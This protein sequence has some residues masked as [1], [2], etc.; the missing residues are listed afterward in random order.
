MS[1]FLAAIQFDQHQL[2]KMPSFPLVYLQTL[3]QKSVVDGLISRS[4]SIYQSICLFLRYDYWNDKL[5]YAFNTKGINSWVQIFN[6][7]LVPASA[8]AEVCRNAWWY[9]SSST[10]TIEHPSNSSKFQQ[11]SWFLLSLFLK[12]FFIFRYFENCL[13][14]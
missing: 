11:H 6:L 4:S 9:S 5:L 3:S 7:K 2:L 8:G 14:H 10:M 12:L 13:R 1:I